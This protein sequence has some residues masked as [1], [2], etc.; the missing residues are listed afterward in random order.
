MET[1]VLPHIGE[2]GRDKADRGGAQLAGGRSRE[3]ERQELAVRPIEGGQEDH[4]ASGGGGVIAQVTLAVWKLPPA[5]LRDL[6][7]DG[8]GQRSCERLLGLEGDE[9]WAHQ[10][11]SIT[12]M[13]SPLA[14]T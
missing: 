1:L 8:D 6:G 12:A 14:A 7:V 13:M 9:Q 2:I 3:D 11:S 10:D 5:H 4:R